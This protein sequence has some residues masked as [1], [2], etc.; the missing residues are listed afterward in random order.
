MRGGE[1][2]GRYGFVLPLSPDWVFSAGFRKGHMI[3]VA[4]LF[5]LGL[6]E[7]ML[8]ITIIECLFHLRNVAAAFHDI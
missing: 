4:T 6:F 2:Y 5:T 1:H 3:H 8:S 7:A